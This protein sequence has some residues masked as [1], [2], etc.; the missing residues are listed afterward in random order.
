MV[1]LNTIISFVLFV[2]NMLLLFGLRKL[3]GLIDKSNIN[4]IKKD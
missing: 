3:F 2:S 1:I 4:K